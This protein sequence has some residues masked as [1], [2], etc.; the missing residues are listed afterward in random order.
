MV[1]GYF[2]LDEVEVLA[3]KVLEALGKSFKL[4]FNYFQNENRESAPDVEV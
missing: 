1:S 3:A 2:I 4:R